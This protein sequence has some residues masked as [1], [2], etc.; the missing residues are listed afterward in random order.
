MGT[1]TADTA[2]ASG[3]AEAVI[4]R[5]ALRILQRLVGLVEFL[6]TVLGGV[7]AVAALGVAF[8]GQTAKGGLHLPVGGPSRYTKDI[9][10]ISLCH[11]PLPAFPLETAPA[12]PRRASS[13]GLGRDP[14]QKRV[15]PAPKPS[16]L[17][18]LRG[19]LAV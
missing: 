19:F 5:A 14:R 18:S 7:V 16:A 11:S 2:F 10:I 17:Y 9:V 6:E 1:R 4:G 15:S 12:R 13:V 8:L 3:M